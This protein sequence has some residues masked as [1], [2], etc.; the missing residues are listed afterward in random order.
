MITVLI[1]LIARGNGMRDRAI[2]E[3][4]ELQ[5]A[6]DAYIREAAGTSPADQ[7]AKLNDLRQSGAISEEEY[8]A[9]KARAKL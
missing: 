2:A 9:L 3:Q 7:I 8:Q 1:Y 4:R 5:K 6:T